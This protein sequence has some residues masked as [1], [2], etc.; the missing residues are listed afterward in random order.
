MNKP[1]LEKVARRRHRREK[2]TI[3]HLADKVYK[4]EPAVK[5]PKEAITE[6]GLPI[7]EQVRKK[8]DPK[9]GGLPTF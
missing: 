7:E 8:W 4:P 9:K 5:D 3:D 1:S 2:S 6:Q